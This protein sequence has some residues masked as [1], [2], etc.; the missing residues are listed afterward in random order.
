[1][2]NLRDAIQVITK[3]NMTFGNYKMPFEHC[4]GRDMVRCLRCGDTYV[5]WWHAGF[6]DL[7]RASSG[8]QTE[9][10]L[11]LG[12]CPKCYSGMTPD[13][14]NVHTWLEENKPLCT[15]HKFV[16]AGVDK[17]ICVHCGEWQ[18]ENA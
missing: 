4:E 2:Y 17:I 5:C 3:Y 14:V 6:R 18:D 1:M 8:K 13:T 15:K 11:E 16:V 7:F 12:F 9:G 10:Y